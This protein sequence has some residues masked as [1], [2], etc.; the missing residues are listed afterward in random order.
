M[1][2]IE[3]AFDS[4]AAATHFNFAFA[5]RNHAGLNK[6]GRNTVSFLT[7][8]PDD[9]P[10]GQTAWCR[11]WFDR[12]GNIIECDIIL[13]QQLARFTTIETGKTDSY[14]IEGVVAHEIG[15]MIGL[16]H[17]ELFTSVMKPDSPPDESWFKGLIDDE[18]ISEYRELYNL[19]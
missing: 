15:H 18:T 13:N 5:G 12:R 17:C 2:A 4:W 7:N 8:W 11:C 16:G 1:R 10:F 9:L 19:D 6:D 3:T 14:Y